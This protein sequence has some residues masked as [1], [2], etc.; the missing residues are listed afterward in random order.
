MGA[1]QVG[2]SDFK[3]QYQSEIYQ[4][5]VNSEIL[6]PGPLPSGAGGERMLEDRV[7]W[8]DAFV[9]IYSITSRENFHAA[10][11]YYHVV[12]SIEA[13]PVIVLLANKHDLGHKR[14]VLTTEGRQM[15][16]AIKCPFY[17]VSASEGFEQIRKVIPGGTAEKERAQVLAFTQ[18]PEE[19]CRETI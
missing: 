17:E 7:T 19:C 11:N 12:T 5:T 4:N 13:K 3:Y 2:K 15:A 18:T 14:K 10:W 16:Q 6:D 9:L 8:G 1:K